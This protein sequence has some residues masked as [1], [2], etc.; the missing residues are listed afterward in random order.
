MLADTVL[1]FSEMDAELEVLGPECNAGLTEDKVDALWSR[2]R[3]AADSLALHIP[4][5]VARN[6]PNSAGEYWW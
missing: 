3:M 6:P 5:L 2:V 4:S 1:H